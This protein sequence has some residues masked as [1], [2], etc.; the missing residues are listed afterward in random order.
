M[1]TSEQIKHSVKVETRNW[2]AKRVIP[3]MAADVR[4]QWAKMFPA[5]APLH[6]AV[7]DEWE[8]IMAAPE[9]RDAVCRVI[10]RHLDDAVGF[11]ANFEADSPFYK[12]HAEQAA[13]FDAM[14]MAFDPNHER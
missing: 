10:R 5:M 2:E 13:K 9:H 4:R 7:A 8:R 6:N 14:L 1:M 12:T 3:G 11:M